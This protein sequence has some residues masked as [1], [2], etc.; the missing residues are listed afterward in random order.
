MEFLFIGLLLGLSAGISPGP[1]LTLVIAETLRYG[2]GAGILV[3]ITPI[4]TDLPIILLTLLILSRLDNYEWLLGLISF[5]GAIVLLI[6]GFDCLTARGVAPGGKATR[7]RAN[8]PVPCD[9]APKRSY[10]LFRARE[11][12][13]YLALGGAGGSPEGDQRLPPGPAPRRG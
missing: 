2:L 13:E 11:V 3:A 6:I 8:C 7:G 12:L 5:V 1:L 4:I 9:Y 10:P